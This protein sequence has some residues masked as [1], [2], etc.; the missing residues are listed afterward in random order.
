MAR[1]VKAIAEHDLGHAA[2]T[3]GVWLHAIRKD[4]LLMSIAM[5]LELMS[6]L[7]STAKKLES[8]KGSQTQDYSYG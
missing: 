3:F 1:C 8:S 7:M 4:L 2:G 5:D 6:T